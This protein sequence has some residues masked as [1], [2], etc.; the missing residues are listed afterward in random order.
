MKHNLLDDIDLTAGL[1]QHQAEQ[2]YVLGKEAVIY[3]LLWLSQ[4][5]AEKKICRPRSLWIP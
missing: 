2:I 5:L 3:A 4:M 1:T